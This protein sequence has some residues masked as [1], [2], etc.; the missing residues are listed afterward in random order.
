MPDFAPNVT[1]RYRLK[2]NAVGR[3][4]TIIFRAARGTVFSA[5]EAVG[6]DAA[7]AIWNANATNIA[8]DFQYLSADVALTDSDLFLPAALPTAFTGGNA[9]TGFS[10]QDGISHVTFGGRG[11]AGSKVHWQAYGYAFA[12]DVTPSVAE[13]D[14]VLQRAEFTTI[15]TAYTGLA[16]VSGLRAIDKS[17]II[18]YAYALLKVNDYWL[19][20]LRA[21]A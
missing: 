1:P 18:F 11:S 2:Y 16:A 19:R 12:P 20:R 14:F 10:K 9:V 3:K 5:M 13:S 21:G 7:E 8:S 17:A 6:Q 4:H 15:D